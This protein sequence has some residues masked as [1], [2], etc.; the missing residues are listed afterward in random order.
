VG[1][2]KVQPAD[3]ARFPDA[4]AAH[5]PVSGTEPRLPKDTRVTDLRGAKPVPVTVTAVPT[6][7]DEGLREMDRGEDVVVMSA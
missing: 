7:P 5:V 2:R 3:E 1:T 6:A 4:S